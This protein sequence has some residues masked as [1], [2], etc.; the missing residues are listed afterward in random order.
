MELNSNDCDHILAVTPKVSK[1]V[2]LLAESLFYV[3]DYALPDI[4]SD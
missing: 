3:L 2:G 4:T 1:H